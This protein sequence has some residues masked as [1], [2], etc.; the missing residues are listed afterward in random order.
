LHLTSLILDDIVDQAWT[1]RGAPCLHR[2]TTPEFAAA[3][4]A[5]MLVRCGQAARSLPEG[6]REAI[7]SSQLALLKGECLE[8]ALEP[9]ARA[10]MSTYYQIIEAKTAS[11]FACAAEVGAACA[12]SA[13]RGVVRAFGRYGREIGFAFQ[14]IDDLLD[15]TGDA[16]VLGKQPGTDFRNGRL[17]L[18]A[19]LLA[20]AHILPAHA[21]FAAARAAI[22]TT[23]IA[24]ACRDRAR[25]HVEAA[26][27]ALQIVPSGEGRTSLEQLAWTMLERSS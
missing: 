4:S 1:R 3:T 13:D 7:V 2:I 5:F 25:R 14:I 27:D 22:A 17:T 18:P 26:I 12:P 21:D 10:S 8:V 15:Y 19:I 6:V 11:L 20:E 9:G 16:A 24:G 23:D